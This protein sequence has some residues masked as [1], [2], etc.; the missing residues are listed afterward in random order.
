MARTPLGGSGISVRPVG[1]GLMGMS[2]FSGTADPDAS[3][4]TVR[5]ATEPGVE[6][7]DTVPGAPGPPGQTALAWLTGPAPRHRPDPGLKRLA[8]VRAN[9]AATSARLSADDVTH[10]DAL[11][12]PA[13]VRGGRYGA[14]DFLPSRRPPKPE[15]APAQAPP[16]PPFT[17][18]EATP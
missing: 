16:P 6:L 7:F 10:L 13:R 11:F 12:D 18:T 14:R 8:Y 1:P 9:L 3:V 2:P 5:E 4:A 17:E 15:T